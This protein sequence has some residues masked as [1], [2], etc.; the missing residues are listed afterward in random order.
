MSEFPQEGP[1]TQAE[2]DE[3]SRIVCIH[4]Q[5]AMD[6]IAAKRLHPAAAAQAGVQMCLRLY[7]DL[8][9]DD[10]EVIRQ[11]RGFLDQ[12]EADLSTA[13]DPNLH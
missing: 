13:N 7:A 2:I 10:D 6:Q 9:G 4:L 1:M 8:L 11:T 3:A 12:W 5:K